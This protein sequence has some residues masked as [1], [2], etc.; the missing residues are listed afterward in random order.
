MQSPRKR[1]HRGLA[2]LALA[3]LGFT[4]W[5]VW[6]ISDSAVR[7]ERPR[8]SLAALNEA[9]ARYLAD[10]SE[11]NAQK[12]NDARGVFEKA[13]A[14]DPAQKS[15]TAQP[16]TMALSAL[17][18]IQALNSMKSALTSSQK[19]IG[20]RLLIVTQRLQGKLPTVLASLRTSVETSK[21]GNAIVDITVTNR[22]AGLKVL[23]PYNFN[24]TSAL[25]HTIRAEVPFD[26]LEEIA[27]LPQVISIREA[28]HAFTHQA[29]PN[30]QSRVDVVT[31][32]RP[33]LT[34]SE[35]A[36]QVKAQLQTALAK[37]VSQSRP[38][39]AAS[40]SL[41]RLSPRSISAVNVSEGD[42][43]HRADDGRAAFLVDGTG[44]KIGVLSNG[45]DSL[46]T[47]QGTGD[48]GPV[49]VLTGQAGTGDEGTAMLEIVHDLA[50]G[51]QLF[52]A[53][54]DPTQAQFAQNIRDL[55]TAGCDI[56]VDD[57]IY[58]DESPLH[59][60]QPGASTSTL[61]LIEQ[62]VNDVTAAGAL[63]FSS[64]GN[65]GNKDDATSGTW[66]GD[67]NANGT[68]AVLAGAGPAH[69][70]GDGGQSVLVPFGAGSDTPPI[71][72]WSDPVDTSNN[73]YDLYD[74]DG[75]LTT[76]FDASTDTQDGVGGDD[77]P[78]EGIFG[79]TFSGERL[80]VALFSGSTRF[81]SLEI[82]RG[83]LA[84]NT[85]GSS[86]GHSQAAA[87]FSTAATPATTGF[88]PGEP[89][90]P[91]PNPFTSANVSETFSSDGPRQLFYQANGSL[92]GAGVLSGQGLIRQKPDITAADG[93]ATSVTGFN[94]FF[95]TSAAAPHAA[96]IAALV[97]SSNLA[98]TP[99]QIRTALTSSAI[100]IE[101]AGTDRDTGA[102]I[103]MGF[104]ALQASGATGIA[105]LGLG[106]QT[107][108]EAGGDGDGFP[109]PCERLN[110]TIPLNN[111]GAATATGISAT[112]SSSTAGV[113]INSAV[114]AYADMPAGGSANNATPF[115]ATLPC[116]L[117]C[118]S[119]VDFTVTVTYSGGSSP[120][121]FNFSYFIGAPGTPVTISYTGPAVP[122]PDAADLSGSNPG[123]PALAPLLVSGVSGKVFD[124]NFRIDGT[125]CTSASGSTTVGL[126]HTFVNDLQLKLIAPAAGPTV[127]VIN[128]TDGS[129]NNFCQTLL[130][131]ETANPSIQTVATANAPF[132][133]TFKPNSPLSAF[134][135][136]DPNGTW[137]FQA[138]DFF[139]GDT[140]N[141]RAYSLIVTPT[142]C[143]TTS[144]SLTCPSSISVPATG[145]TGAIVNYP[146]AAV[147][148]G[149]GV[150]NYSTASGTLFPVGTTPVTVTGAGGATCNFNV[151]VTPPVPPP[152]NDDCAN[153][154]AVTPANCGFT[155][156]QDTTNA[157]DQAGE[158]G[159]S[160]T[161]QSNSVWYSYTNITANDIL[162]TVSTCTSNFDTAVQVWE[163]T[164]ASCNFGG[165]VA[166]ACNDDACGDGFQSLTSFIAAPGK[167][168][169]IQSG[170]F[171][172][173]TGSLTTSIA[174]EVFNCPT[175]TIHGTLGSGSPDHAFTTGNQTGRLN[176]NGISSSCATPKSCNIFTASGSRA[177]DAYTFPNTSGADACAQVHFAVNTASGANYQV[178]AY[179][180]SYDPN[181]ICTNYLADPGLSSGGG[182]QMPTDMSF[183]VPNG[184]SVVLVVHTTNPGE[185]GGLYT[186][187]VLGNLCTS[188]SLTCPT[189]VSKTTDPGQNG[190][191]VNYPAPSTT[192]SCGTVNC[193]P[194]SGSFFPVGT[195]PVTCTS[196]A[197]PSCSFN[198]TVHAPRY[199]TTV[200]SAGTLD[201][202]SFGKV[203]YPDFTVRLKD[204]TTG[205]ANLRYNITATQGISSYCPATQS[206]VN[207]RFRNS[208]NT[209]THAQVKFDIHR[210][211]VVSGGNDIVF[212]FNSNGLGAGGS[213]TTASLSPNID[214]DFSHYVYWIEATV[215]RDNAAQFADLGSVEIYES[216]GTPCP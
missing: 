6:S 216:A 141:I 204:G 192:G 56:I 110:F 178:N 111:N 164:G 67:F 21:T 12:L 77:Q 211:N 181:N 83:T 143:A 39:T 26:K 133:G 105:V 87:A 65:E 169:M 68:P 9:A 96:A 18:Q 85:T 30:L 207:V 172:G 78:F 47:S 179:L 73:D 122:I 132:T 31:L 79:G 36:K 84:I 150:L 131:D 195:T 72:H 129:G 14:T 2:L 140:G 113:Q 167:T 138:Q 44:V 7:A 51:A 92:F 203:I 23:D 186:L 198:V 189:D 109:E 25:N 159:S 125:S 144:C 71:L 91:F 205:T 104:Q 88:G 98:L 19:K 37:V 130:D 69:N 54:A 145:P 60:G 134:R 182:P 89:N 208:D 202:D 59:D 155:D 61:G 160:C 120:Q 162:V 53:T 168:Y 190:A 103:V 100:D 212:S 1:T 177:F 55:R 166:V 24:I 112:L 16:K 66:E 165:F 173:E 170:G 97:K 27:A 11:V 183:T 90:G 34:R 199:W 152:A 197:G 118:G 70:F 76:I 213:F 81:I 163:Q 114:S 40:A 45:V 188:C 196:T 42:R 107:F 50:P 180:D 94:P 33:K 75:S 52:F 115:T 185:T 121:A 119:T 8:A 193:A 156:T 57:V 127:N 201:E 28:V 15:T 82:F 108:T 49:T 64:A 46:A 4:C 41:R 102:G 13:A 154:I 135:G 20:S 209:G 158:P 35:R 48:L 5:Q 147:T 146:E 10:P 206:V 116:S 74:L 86:H 176:R 106:N 38:G 123:A 191:V 184:H 137:N 99:A 128:N 175:T 95:G 32:P 63:Y 161:V 80:V 43:T 174:C 117:A 139:L 200:G 136:I 93:V 194:A 17:V 62:A 151:T 126:D 210:T 215:F 142:D 153:A 148:G 3:V 214:F 149:C 29:P 58:L 157:T 171:D 22:T 101:A 187:T 124:L